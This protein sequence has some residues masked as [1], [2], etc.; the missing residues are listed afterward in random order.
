MKRKLLYIAAVLI[1]LSL[2]AGGTLAYFTAEDTA[3]NVITSGGVSI[4][5]VERQRVDGR[6]HAYPDG[7]MRVMPGTTVSKIVTVE[8][9]DH[10]A[11]VRLRYE[12]SAYNAEGEPLSVSAAA[13]K[14]AVVIEPDAE[15]W[16][17]RG[18]WWYCNVPLAEGEESAPLFESVVFSAAN[19]GNEFQG[20]TVTVDVT[21]QAVQRENNGQTALKAQ[22]WP[23]E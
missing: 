19:M 3:R 10:S 13:L 11:W 22:G 17:R 18:E 14:R 1:V 12:V 8:G 23:Q 20:T 9:I 5:L 21:A 4:A 2:I 16:T 7:P 15:N 6:L